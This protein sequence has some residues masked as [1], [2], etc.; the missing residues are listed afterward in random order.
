MWIKRRDYNDRIA[1][2]IKYGREQSG[3]DLGN[4]SGSV[5]LILK[6]GVFSLPSKDFFASVSR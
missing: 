5:S 3:W 4:P 1:E 2:E 6:E